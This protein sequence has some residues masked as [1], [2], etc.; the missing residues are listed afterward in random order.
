[1]HSAGFR[2]GTPADRGEA[3]GLGLSVAFPLDGST[4]ASGSMGKTIRLV[5]CHYH[6]TQLDTPPLPH[7]LHRHRFTLR[8][9]IMC[10]RSFPNPTFIY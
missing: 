4:L 1:M 7:L 3:H 10:D 9:S 6:P 8:P 5:G 2:G